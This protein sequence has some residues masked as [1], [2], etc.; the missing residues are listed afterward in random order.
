MPIAAMI[1]ATRRNLKKNG[2]RQV[3][4]RILRVLRPH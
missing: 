1:T 4:E 2:C 3:T